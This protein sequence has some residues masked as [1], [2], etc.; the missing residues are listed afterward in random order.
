MEEKLRMN[1]KEL[2]P[3]YQFKITLRDTT[4]QVWRLIQVPSSYSFG[5][6]NVAIQDANICQNL[7]Y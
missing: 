4:P 7:H 3:A 1:P 5:D 2:E 6:L